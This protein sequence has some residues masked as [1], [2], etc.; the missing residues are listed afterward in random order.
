MVKFLVKDSIMIDSSINH[1]QISDNQKESIL[2]SDKL[3]RDKLSWPPI[4]PVLISSARYFNP[5]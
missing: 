5:F 3:P 1:H 2:I 4:S